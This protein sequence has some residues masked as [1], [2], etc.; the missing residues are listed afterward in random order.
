MLGLKN[1]KLQAINVFNAVISY[2]YYSLKLVL[3]AN[4]SKIASSVKPVKYL[5]ILIN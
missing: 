3:H 4:T 2:L 1:V 5:G